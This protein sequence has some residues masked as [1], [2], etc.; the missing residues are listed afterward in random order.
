M[1]KTHAAPSPSSLAHVEMLKLDVNP[2]KSQPEL[3][4]WLAAGWNLKSTDAI[5][6]GGQTVYILAILTR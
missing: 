2:D 3:E 1:F 4:E 5:L 6:L